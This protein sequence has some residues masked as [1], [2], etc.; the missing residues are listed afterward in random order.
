MQWT[1]PYVSVGSVRL[2]LSREF[3][4]K[5]LIRTHWGARPTAVTFLMTTTDVSAGLGAGATVLAATSNSSTLTP[6]RLA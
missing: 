4:G 5:A 3:G 6:Q 1:D 2:D